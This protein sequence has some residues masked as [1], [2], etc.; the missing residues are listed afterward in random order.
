MNLLRYVLR[1][2]LGI[3]L[4]YIVQRIDR[5]R[6]TPAQRARAWNAASWGAALYAF[7]PFS[8]LGWAW[9]TRQD[10][11]GWGR[12]GPR[13]AVAMSAALLGAGLLAAIVLVALIA[14]VDVLI[15]YLAGAPE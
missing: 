10:V 13:R 3:A 7:G 1:M 5:R 11:Q 12:A 14:G 6:L 4:P 8:M 2:V 15:A 9:V